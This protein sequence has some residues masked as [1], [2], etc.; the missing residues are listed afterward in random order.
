MVD[1]KNK[2]K[3][4]APGTKNEYTFN[5]KNT[6]SVN[7]SYVV[8]FVPSLTI[9]QEVTGFNNFPIKARLKDAKNK[10]LLGSEN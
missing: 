1:S 5:L 10:Y 6:G 2:D 4:I 3:I 8:T 7:L 9:N